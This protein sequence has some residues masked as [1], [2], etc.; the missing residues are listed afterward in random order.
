MSRPFLLWAIIVVCGSQS[1]ANPFALGPLLK[2]GGTPDPCI[3]N[4]SPGTTC[5][6]GGTA[7]YLGSMNGIRYMINS[8]DVSRTWRGTG[9]TNASI[10][11][12]ETVTGNATKSSQ[13]YTGDVNTAAIVADAVNN[14]SDSAA[15]YCYDLVEGGYSDWYLP[16]KSELAFIFCHSNQSGNRSAST[17]PEDTNC[18]TYGVSTG[19]TGF[20]TG[21][22]ITSTQEGASSGIQVW[23]MSFGSGA[24]GPLA[25][26]NS[27]NFRCVRRF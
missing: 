22:Y 24:Q 25:K 3:S 23:S 19:I 26:S 27:Y 14:G 20:S 16:S 13:S 6:G 21:S 1:E 5:G 18:G 9:G 10:S 8:A 17:P 11:G 12:V 15:R 7:Q 2:R 4:P